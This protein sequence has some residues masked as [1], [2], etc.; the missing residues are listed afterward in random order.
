[1]EPAR[2]YSAHED[3][4][5]RATSATFFLTPSRKRP[6][7]MTR[8]SGTIVRQAAVYAALTGKPIHVANA[9]AH[10]PRPGLRAQHIKVLE[11]IAQLVSGET[12]G[13]QLGSREFVF[14]PG[15]RDEGQSYT[16]DIG[17][18]GSTTLLALAILPILAF[19]PRRVS[20]ELQGGLFQDFAPSVYHLQHVMLP[21]LKLLGLEADLEMLRPGYV[22][23]GG[24]RVCMSV[25]PVRDRFQPF[26]LDQ[27]P[28]VE[29]LWGIAL[30]SHLEERKVSHRMAAAAQEVL[31]GAGY[32]ASIESRYENT[33]LQPGA[34]LALFAD[35]AGGSR[36]GADM[37]GAP[38]RTSETIGRAVAGQLLK[39]IETG[40]TLDQ[41][42]AD[43]I[44]PFA[45][46]AAG[47]TRFRVA[48]ITDH[49]ESNAWLA[50]KFI[51]AEIA[52]QGRVLS[53]SGVGFRS[54]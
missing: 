26:V 17:S 14:R 33:A 23:R 4:S 31:T 9:R 35:L 45:A 53:I 2:G 54:R 29:R 43:Q 30:A 22:P 12:D 1:V 36:L 34:G 44:I 6:R 48:A 41:H 5:F 18:A 20:V 27:I 28:V 49:M 52:F 8:R 24:G 21:L 25:N 11:A 13:V 47:Q 32:R 39:E 3:S 50:R 51:G 19:G 16:W 46:L 37:A 7:T 15:A 38:R 42:A 10:R 40:A